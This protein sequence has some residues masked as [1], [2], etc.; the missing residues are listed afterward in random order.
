MDIGYVT[1]LQR[2]AESNK[3]ATLIFLYVPEVTSM[4]QL[5]ENNNTLIVD[6]DKKIR[7]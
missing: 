4:S 1:N 6:T 5:I 7:E 3:E 2:H